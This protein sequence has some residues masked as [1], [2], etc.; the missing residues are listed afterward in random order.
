MK[1]NH[2]LVANLLK[3]FNVNNNLFMSD[4]NIQM[5]SNKQFCEH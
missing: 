5:S 4:G 3:T 1:M 2:K